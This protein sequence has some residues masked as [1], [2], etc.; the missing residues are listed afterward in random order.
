MTLDATRLATCQS[1]SPGTCKRS[2]AGVSRRAGLTGKLCS[3]QSGAIP[4]MTR[5]LLFEFIYVPP[6]GPS[7][8]VLILACDHHILERLFKSRGFST[9]LGRVFTAS[10]QPPLKAES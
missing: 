1:R 5:S 3:A 8:N 10:Y 6:V 2:K 9:I 7:T 4:N